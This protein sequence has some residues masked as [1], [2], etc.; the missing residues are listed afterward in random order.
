MEN[1][2]FRNQR[3]ILLSALI[4]FITSISFT[5]SAQQ[6]GAQ[7]THYTTVWQGENGQN[8]MNF[9]VI[10]AILEDLP[11]AV[12]N[13]IAVFSGSACVGAK[14]LTQVINK[15]DNT[16][17]LTIP[18]SQDDGTGNGF[19]DNDTIIFKIWDNVNQKEMTIK[20]LTYRNDQS[21]WST[22]G[23]FSA[24]ATAVAELVSYVET[25]QTIQ[26]IK[27]YNLV[28][29]NVTV[30]NPD[31]SV[32]TKSLCD[33]N[34][35][36]K[37]QDEA[38]NSYENW[39]TFG[40]WIN[41]VGSIQKTEGYKFK[42]AT[43]C[44]LQLTGRP[45]VLPLDIPLKAGWNI[46]SFPHTA[47]VNALSVIQTLIDQNL[48]IKV[49]DE[50]GNSIENWGIFGGW[51][52]AIGNFVPGKAYKVKMNADATL[53]IAQNYLKSAIAMNQ[54]EKTQYFSTHIEGNGIDQMN[55]NLVGLREAGLSVGDELAAFDG[56]I[57]VGTLKITEQQ[58]AQ[59]SASLIASY[60]TDEKNKNGFAD[61]DKIKI[62]TWNQLSGNEAE[63]QAEIVSGQMTY[64]RNSTVLAKLKSAGTGSNKL[65]DLVKIDI[66]P[67]PS[68]G[69]VTVR[70]SE[71]PEPGSS[72][73]ILDLSG[74]KITSRTV[75]GFNE[76]FDLTG[77]PAGIY[78]V[79]ASLGSDELLQKLI[80]S[81]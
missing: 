12:G 5:A 38:G 61:G 66:F 80:I 13:E 3:S 11:L 28:S 36:I 57:C 51:K 58:V 73:D 21:T 37:V 54:P 32:V 40:G 17:F 19:V 6:T 75:A 43:N 2:Y 60:S 49:Q 34:A 48:L 68:V 1:L 29:T 53:T 15:T 8:H 33:Q 39:G 78:L 26:L 4:V 30:S 10:S 23:R 20:Q 35:L 71:L 56:N 46:I 42:V 16:T 74:R 76:M 77:Q 18:A 24:G 65:S 45:V 55:I 7:P 72:I 52:N 25:T 67:N 59:G 62:Y 9:I 47:T 79:K 50:T 22:N 63:M 69:K 70:F 41:K 27:G 81:K 14:K 31:L 44:T 64:E